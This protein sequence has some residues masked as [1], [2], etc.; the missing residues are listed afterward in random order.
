MVAYLGDNL[1]QWL[2]WGNNKATIL[3][4]GLGGALTLV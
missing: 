1:L 2:A 4:K 3:M